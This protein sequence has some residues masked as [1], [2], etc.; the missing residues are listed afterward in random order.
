V[1]EWSI[2][3]AGHGGPRLGEAVGLDR[4]RS[5]LLDHCPPQ[6]GGAL[7]DALRSIA[8]LP[9]R[10]SHGDL[11]RKNILLDRGAVGVLDWEFFRADGIPGRDL[12]QLAVLARGGRPDPG[13]VASLARGGDVPGASVRPYLVRAGL[14]EE[15]LRPALLV[16]LVLWAAHEAERLATP[17][18]VYRD[19]P[20]ERLLE[21]CGSYLV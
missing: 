6:L 8:L 21:A 17:G 10:R 5:R 7:E 9:S 19:A 16:L 12:L 4:L 1:A 2:R 3:L 11:D 15:S 14:P 13:V 18:W 20:Y